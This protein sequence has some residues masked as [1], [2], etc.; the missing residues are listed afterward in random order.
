[1]IDCDCPRCGSRN[2]KA[3][4]VLYGNGTRRS[5]RRTSGWFHYRRSLG[6]HCSTTSGQ[7]QTVTAELAAPPTA[8]NG[9]GLVFLVIIVAFA[10]GGVTGICVGFVVLVLGAMADAGASSGRSFQDWRSTFRCGRCGHVFSVT[11]N[12]GPPLQVPTDC[13]DQPP[14]L[15]NAK[16]GRVSPLVPSTLPT[17]GAINE[18]SRA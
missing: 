1:V 8:S 17:R 2:T 7:S 4:S 16:V 12:S 18:S 14:A 10:I 13:N 15:G 5:R 9:V 6:V 3:L 11:E